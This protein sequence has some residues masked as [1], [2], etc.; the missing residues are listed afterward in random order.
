MRALE[1]R[2]DS[3]TRA[4]AGA[5]ALA[6]SD[7]LAA[8]RAAAAAASADTTAGTQPQQARLGQNALNPEISVTGDLRAHARHPGPQVDNFLAR[9]FEGTPVF[10]VVA[11]LQS[12]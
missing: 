1:A 8:I 9:E 12:G 10:D 2:I 11:D 6:P 5:A 7:E 3:L 4:G